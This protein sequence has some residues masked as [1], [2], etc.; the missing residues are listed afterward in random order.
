MRPCEGAPGPRR[1]TELASKSAVVTALY[2]VAL[3][4][5]WEETPGSLTPVRRAAGSRGRFVGAG[6]ALAQ[7]THC[8]PCLRANPSCP[9]SVHWPCLRGLSPFASAH[10]AAAVASLP[11]SWL[12]QLCAWSTHL[13]EVPKKA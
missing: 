8:V 6:R 13:V 1:A 4:A 10:S 11:L 9:H 12:L 3:E 7:K 5:P 2:F